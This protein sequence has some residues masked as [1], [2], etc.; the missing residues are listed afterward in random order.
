MN[1][2]CAPEYRGVLPSLTELYARAKVDASAEVEIKFGVLSDRGF[3]S[4]VPLEFYNEQLVKL[5]TF[6]GWHRVDDWTDTKDFYFPDHIRG[7]THKDGTVEFERKQ[8]VAEHDIQCMQHQLDLRV[9]YK[10]EAPVPP[11]T[12]HPIWVR[13]KKR[14][15]YHYNNF[16]FDFSYVWSGASEAAIAQEPQYEI[17]IEC[18]DL[19]DERG[20][21]Y[22][23][24]SMLMKAHDLL[25]RETAIEFR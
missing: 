4:G 18:L 15:S 7:T 23:A 17:E 25:G 6:E 5:D 13:I 14:K 9:S 16:R 3:A 22:L 10:Q 11:P 1:V 20:C 19:H 2:E 24:L 21:E 12:A 8:L